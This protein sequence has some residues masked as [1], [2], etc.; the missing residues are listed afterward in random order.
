MNASTNQMATDIAEV[1]GLAKIQA[2]QQHENND[3]RAKAIKI[4]ETCFESPARDAESRPAG[5]LKPSA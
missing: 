3:T 5:R 2:L 4:L 1:E